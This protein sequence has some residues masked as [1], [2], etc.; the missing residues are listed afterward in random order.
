MALNK[1]D[2]FYCPSRREDGSWCRWSYRDGKETIPS[3]LA[4]YHASHHPHHRTL[5]R[6]PWRQPTG[7]RH[8][9]EAHNA[10]NPTPSPR[11][12]SPTT[13][14]DSSKM[15]NSKVARSAASHQM[16]D[17]V[18]H[19][20]TSITVADQL[21]T[22]ILGTWAVSLT[23]V[24]PPSDSFGRRPVSLSRSLALTILPN[25]CAASGFRRQGVS[26][27]PLPAEEDGR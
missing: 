15:S 25:L 27:S 26:L 14:S 21:V 7:C 24:A 9:K 6:R 3:A 4:G 12:T 20:E 5:K 22:A 18:T 19:S 23:S 2:G 17:I 8:G 10:K 11:S 1:Y 13:T 16:V